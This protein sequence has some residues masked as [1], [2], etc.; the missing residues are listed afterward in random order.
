MTRPR[1]R[2]LI[3]EPPSF[4]DPRY[5]GNLAAFCRDA[6]RWMA[7]VHADILRAE[8]PAENVYA[9]TGDTPTVAFNAASADLATTRNV[10]ATV[11]R[12]LI[13]KRTLRSK[14]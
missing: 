13:T 14:G 7:D 1:L 5:Q 4:D 9:V 12:D 6:S 3:A 11:I 10:L 2:T 8:R